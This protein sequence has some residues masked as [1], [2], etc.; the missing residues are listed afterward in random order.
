MYIGRVGG[1]VGTCCQPP[2]LCV[3][4]AARRRWAGGVKARG[5]LPTRVVVDPASCPPVPA[6]APPLRMK[7]ESQGF[8]ENR[9]LA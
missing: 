9:H 8:W 1:G 4:L 5:P 7:D 2:T 3:T 6:L